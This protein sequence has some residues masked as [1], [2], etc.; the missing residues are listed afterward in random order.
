MVRIQRQKAWHNALILLV[1]LL[2]AL[3]L[4]FHRLG[5]QSLW[6]DEGTSVA[7][8]QRDLATIARNASHDIHPPL[9]Y[10]MLHYWV[11]LAGTGEGSVRALSALGG[12]ALVAAVYLLAR[13]FGT[14]TGL[15][16]AL[17]TALSPFTIYY[18]QETRMYIFLA[19]FGALTM[20]AYE[21]FVEGVIG[22]R[23]G[24]R[25]TK[26][27]KS[28]ALDAAVYV[29]TGVL[30]V[31]THYLGFALLFAQ[32][33]A[34]LLRWLRHPPREKEAM[35]KGWHPLLHWGLSQCII[36]LAYLPWLAMSW[37]ALRSWP[38]VRAPFSLAYFVTDAS[39]TLSLG[40]TVK[41]GLRTQL[42]G[43]G[44]SLLILPGLLYRPHRD[45]GS[46]PDRLHMDTSLYL[47]LPLGLIFI[48]S[49]RRPMYKPKFLLLIA[50]AYHIL[51]ARGIVALGRLARRATAR[52]RWVEGA[53]A[54]SLSLVVCAASAHSLVGLYTDET[55]FRDDYRGAVA[56]IEA[57]SGPQDA[58]VINAPSQIETVD[59]YYDGDLSQYP[60]PE[61]R[62]LDKART[63]RALQDIVA[64]HRRI[65]GIF[66]AT[67]ESDPQGFVENWLD[68]HCYKAMD[69]WFGNIRLLVYAVPRESSEGIQE[70]TDYVWAEKVRL[71]GHTL[72]TPQPESGEIVQLSLF[73]EALAPLTE[74]YKV[75][76]HLVDERGN[77]VAQRDTEPVGGRRLTTDWEV[78][79]IITDNH[80]ILIPPGTTPGAHQLRVGL[81][82]LVDGARLPVKEEDEK[83]GDSIDLKK[84]AVR[85]P[86]TPPPP[87]AL[88][89]Q[90]DI[91][92]QTETRWGGLRLLGYSL[93]RLGHEHQGEPE[94]LHPDETATLILFWTREAAG[95]TA[96][97]E[98]ILNLKRDD[99]NLWE[100]ELQITGG[101]FPPEEWQEGEKV[102][103]IHRLP[104][105]NV[106]P[107][108]YDLT[109]C[110]RDGASHKEYRLI[111]L[112]IAAGDH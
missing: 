11:R 40:V 64:Q 21:E 91:P 13:P 105:P 67:R 24:K 89:M 31:Y 78:G 52:C 110:P 48:L 107:G 93:Y 60:L 32:N 23:G 109:L 94:A 62:P 26:R 5:A 17:L 102:R 35:R 46:T 28:V 30:L 103:D 18:S 88:D 41:E 51:Q 58:I 65:Y 20:L 16:A 63:G 111:R 56:Y 54:A 112:A 96:P 36:L 97:T 43:L 95:D 81:Y 44:T 90:H 29:L 75:F 39:R 4:R 49:L 27:E 38:A 101:T 77:I 9:Y 1:I 47:L 59:Y 85:F 68:A 70:R 34:F 2:L 71:Q 84:I 92:M 6:N 79:E 104:I 7:L 8:A 57:T 80:G 100:R 106:A 33:V 74:R 86:S 37:Q 108:T 76:L 53:V 73:W 50:P 10:Y 69:S 87:S 42:Y 55:F 3:A 82:N 12:V 66:W 61:Q 25:E 14:A 72:L 99:Q 19:L 98:M 15:L 22:D 83:K 45:R